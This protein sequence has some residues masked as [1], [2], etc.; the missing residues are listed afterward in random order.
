MRNPTF[1]R[2]Y[3]AHSRF[4]GI[5]LREER[6]LVAFAASWYPFGG[7]SAE[8][9]MLTFGLQPSL[10][11]TRLRHVLDH[12]TGNQ[13]GISPEMHALLRKRCLATVD[14]VAGEDGHTC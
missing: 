5:R 13:L 4:A 11:Y 6:E 1:A 14:V 10:Y 3:T 9:I 12:Y 2:G 8:D 7:A